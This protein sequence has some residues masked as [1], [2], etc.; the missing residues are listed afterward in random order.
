MR[1]EFQNRWWSYTSV[2][3]QSVQTTPYPNPYLPQISVVYLENKSHTTK[4]ED[5]A[6]Q[7]Y[8]LFVGEISRIYS[9]N[10]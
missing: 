10:V 3:K 2:E 1:L 4:W 7:N 6:S 5:T 9:R 8:G